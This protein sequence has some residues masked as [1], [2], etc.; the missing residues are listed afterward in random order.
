MS[1]AFRQLSV[2]WFR[3]NVVDDIPWKWLARR[4]I[5]WSIYLAVII[6]AY[7]I[8]TDVTYYVT[9]LLI[10][11]T[12]VVLFIFDFLIGFIEPIGLLMLFLGFSFSEA[13]AMM[14]DA[15]IPLGTFG[16][17]AYIFWRYRILQRW[18]AVLSRVPP[19][20]EW[21]GGYFAPSLALISFMTF[22]VLYFYSSA[23]VSN[24]AYEMVLGISLITG[25]TVLWFTRAFRAAQVIS[26]SF[27]AGAHVLPILFP[28]AYAYVGSAGKNLKISEQKRSS[29]VVLA[30]FRGGG[31]KTAGRGGAKG[32]AEIIPG[33]VGTK[34]GKNGKTALEGGMA[35][36]P[37]GRFGSQHVAIE[38]ARALQAGAKVAKQV[39]KTSVDLARSVKNSGTPKRFGPNGETLRY[40]A[41]G[42]QIG[43]EPTASEL[44]SMQREA[45]RLNSQSRRTE[46]HHSH[47]KQMGGK[48]AQ[49]LT[50]M[51]DAA[52]RQLHNDMRQFNRAREFETSGLKG[53]KN[54]KETPQ[55]VVDKRLADFY[56]SRDARGGAKYD[57][58]AKDFFAQ[59][60]GARQ[61]AETRMAKEMEYLKRYPP[62]QYRQ[63]LQEYYNRP[64]VKAEYSAQ[65]KGA[66]K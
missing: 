28:P 58:A 17:A 6:P 29:H 21:L 50:R 4:A 10:M 33:F 5:F 62:E 39:G 25:F 19:A 48:D 2:G 34:V 22:A 63:R 51:Q 54:L 14:I 46:E 30:R 3:F 24:T 8:L 40:D 9:L 27:L 55:E 44:R 49:K 59:N 61:A 32:K 20:E 45:A 12:Q 36:W 38:G 42:R 18:Y 65:A 57:Q 1:D 56:A 35:V 60:P 11:A 26:V 43:K 7:M 52:H 37:K 16:I 64:E 13:F 66:G 23:D 15:L 53:K 31:P 41:N 47:P